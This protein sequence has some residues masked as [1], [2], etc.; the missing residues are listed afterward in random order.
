MPAIDPL[1]RS[2]MHRFQPQFEPKVSVTRDVG[3]EIEDVVGHAIGARR[4]RK[5]DDSGKVQSFTIKFFQF[6]YRIIGIRVALKIGDELLRLVSLAD[7]RRA[8]FE[9]L[10]DGSARAVILRGMTGIVTVDAA[11][12]GDFAVAIGTCEIHAQ[13][14][15]VDAR[16]E[17]VFEHAVIRVEALAVPAIL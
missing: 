10:G 16:G 14:Y 7:S 5:T 11:A 4:N 13:A 12:D 8:L 9:L 1:K 17:R 3:N 15:L 6:H 2:V